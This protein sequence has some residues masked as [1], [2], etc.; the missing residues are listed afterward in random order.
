MTHSPPAASLPVHPWWWRLPGL[1]GR[2]AAL[3]LMGI[4][5]I[6]CLRILWDFWWVDCVY[7]VV[8]AAVFWWWAAEP[9]DKLRKKTGWVVLLGN[10]LVVWRNVS[11]G[12]GLE[13]LVAWGLF[14]LAH[15]RRLGR[16]GQGAVLCAHLTFVM[17]T[18]TAVLYNF[19]T[20][21]FAPGV[22]RQSGVR[23]LMTVDDAPYMTHNI[24]FV[25]EDCGRRHWLIGASTG[26]LFIRVN[27]K[28]FKDYK[29]VKR[30]RSTDTLFQD[31][32]NNRAFVGDYRGHELYMVDTRT[33]RLL[34]TG[35]NMGRTA[36]VI[37]DPDLR[38]VV[39]SED[40]GV[41][42]YRVDYQ[43]LNKPRVT[44][45]PFSQPTDP[46]YSRATGLL[47][48]VGDRLV[49]VD[50]WQGKILASVDHR[51]IPD[52][53]IIL[54]D[55]RQ[56]IYATNSLSGELNIFDMHTL[57]HR[58]VWPTRLGDRYLFFD[59]KYDAIV[60]INYLN[61]QLTALD[62]E[63]GDVLVRRQIGRRGRVINVTH[64]GKEILVATRVGLVAIERRLWKHKVDGGR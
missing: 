42:V 53:H 63:T 35:K 46:R 23:V 30:G 59:E 2:G 24:R 56:V 61:G 29:W 31:C 21:W 49:K 15:R 12:P 5:A 43:N 10:F 50:P 57:A 32:K 33:M 55:T 41:H 52:P 60:L 4:Y 34:W 62:A 40:W 26:P 17:A 28:N 18:R 44:V 38:M 37:G 6:L 14:R 13:P 58:G 54:D 47:Y 20:P 25:A 1:L 39:V 45:Y 48:F 11:G 64:D 36:T 22:D 51:G 19:D 3:G 7:P 27:K 16:V 9:K 8:M